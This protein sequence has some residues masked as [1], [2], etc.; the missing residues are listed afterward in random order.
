[1]P[2]DV[3]HGMIEHGF[4]GTQPVREFVRKQ[5]MAWGHPIDP[6][7]VSV[8]PFTRNVNRPARPF[9][10]LALAAVTP[11]LSERLRADLRSVT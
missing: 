6:V 7:M 3:Y 2:L 8:R 11:S 1:M 5:T 9:L 4:T 10:G